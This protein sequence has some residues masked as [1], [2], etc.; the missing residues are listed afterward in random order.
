MGGIL[1]DNVGSSSEGSFRILVVD[2]EAA[3]REF[4]AIAFSE[5]GF[6]VQTASS[7]E[8]AMRIL[9]SGG[10]VQ[11]VFTDIRMPG[12]NGVE[13]LRRVRQA[14]NETEVVIMTS[15]ATSIWRA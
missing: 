10:P 9:T 6:A 4:M 12:M 3:I 2:D 1:F 7:G 13:L 15:D 11:A 5:E 8:E 14:W